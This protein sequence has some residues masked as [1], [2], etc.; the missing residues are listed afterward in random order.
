MVPGGR[1][2]IVSF[3]PFRN[4]LLSTESP[5]QLVEVRL[6]EYSGFTLQPLVPVERNTTLLLKA[7]SMILMVGC[8]GA[9]VMICAP[10]PWMEQIYV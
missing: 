8:G 2:Q 5:N 9:T 6:V 3:T 7:R 10:K 4:L 1:P